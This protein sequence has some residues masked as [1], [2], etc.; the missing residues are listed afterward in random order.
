MVDM[1]LVSLIDVFTI[2]IFFLLAHSLDVQ[3]LSPP[4]GVRLPQARAEQ[5]PRDGIELAVSGQTVLL[6]GQRVATLS[7]AGLAPLA[8]ALAGTGRVA[9]GHRRCAAAGGRPRT[10][11]PLAARADAQRGRGRPDRGVVRRAAAGGRMTALALAGPSFRGG[12]L[13]FAVAPE[14]V[15]R[16]RRSRR[17]AWAGAAVRAGAAL[18]AAAGGRARG[19]TAAPAGGAAA[20]HA[21][22]T[23]AR[24]RRPRRRSRPRRWQRRGPPW[25]CPKRA[26]RNPGAPLANATSARKPPPASACWR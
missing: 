16:W 17:A 21:R 5:A 18:A 12:R 3:T 22:S 8:A 19:T 4:A 26:D 11:L 13:P 6:Q 15:Q 14:D 23:D 2:L 20:D 24:C 25:W 10:A 9:A 1:N 7:D